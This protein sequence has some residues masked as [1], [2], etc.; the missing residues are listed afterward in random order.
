V[1]TATSTAELAF[2]YK[3]AKRSGPLLQQ[4]AAM[5]RSLSM[6]LAVVVPFVVPADG[7]GC[8]G[9]RGQR[10]IDMLHEVA[11][12]DADRAR[13][14]LDRTGVPYSVTVVPGNSVPEIVE[15]FTSDGDRQLALPQPASGTGFSRSD[16]RRLRRDAPDAVRVVPAG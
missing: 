16:L 15:S 7:P 8:C 6:E 12:E 13:D 11:E 9:I 3:S 10:W 1:P 4:A 2:A 5:A 14:L